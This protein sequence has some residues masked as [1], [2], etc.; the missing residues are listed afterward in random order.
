MWARAFATFAGT[1]YLPGP[2]LPFWKLTWT[3]GGTPSFGFTLYGM[4][5]WS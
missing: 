2:V 1:N 5:V 3:C 4:L